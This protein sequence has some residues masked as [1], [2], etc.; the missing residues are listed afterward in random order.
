MDKQAIAEQV[1]AKVYPYDDEHK[2]VGRDEVRSAEHND[3]TQGLV[4][5]YFRASQEAPVAAG[6]AALYAYE[7]QVPQVAQAKIDGLRDRY[8]ITDDRTLGFFETHAS[9]TKIRCRND[10]DHENSSSSGRV[11]RIA[12]ST[13]AARA[14]LRAQ[15]S[16]MTAQAS[17]AAA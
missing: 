4:D 5:T 3:A 17:R 6:V 2:G 11:C 15:R 1:F 8:G 10:S 7:A 14:V 13:D 9:V 12:S 16:S